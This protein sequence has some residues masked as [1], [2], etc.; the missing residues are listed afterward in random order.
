MKGLSSLNSR[1]C[2]I[3]GDRKHLNDF[4]TDGS[5]RVRGI[6]K[7]CERER[8][9]VTR[10]QRGQRTQEKFFDERRALAR[11]RIASGMKR[12]RKCGAVKPLEHF[13]RS[14]KAGLD[15]RRGSCKPCEKAVSNGVQI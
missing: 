15:G 12:C 10:R 9:T 4:Q 5:P 11:E 1:I 8:Q 2:T 6:C 7:G 13:Y 3:C 14:K